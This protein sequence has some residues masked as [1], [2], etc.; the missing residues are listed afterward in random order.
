MRTR[1]P[2]ATLDQFILIDIFYLCKQK[3]DGTILYLLMI[4]QELRKATLQRV[5][6]TVRTLRPAQDHT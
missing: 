1:Y 6:D 5:H 4:P 2:R 3:R